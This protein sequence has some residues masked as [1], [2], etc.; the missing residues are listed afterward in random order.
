MS[1]IPSPISRST[2]LAAMATG[3]GERRGP[4]TEYFV[5]GVLS[6]DR[7][8]LARTI[9]LLESTNVHHAATARDVLAALLPESGRSIRVG[10]TG[11]PGVGKSTFIDQFGLNL[12]E[13]GHRV[14]V[15]A[16]DPTSSRT[17]GSI[18]GDKTRMVRLSTHDRAF[19][20]PSPA[21]SVL[22]GV[23]RATRE[24]IVVCEAAGYDVILV[25]TVGVGQS[26]TEVHDMVDFFLVLM[27]SGAGDDL[28]GI[29]KGVLELADMVAINKADGDN[30]ARARRAAGEYRS[31]LHLIRPA[32]TTW[33]PP[34]IT[35]SALENEGLDE[36]WQNIELHRAKT[37]ATGEFAQRRSNQ[38]V[39]WM[40]VML[41]ERLLAE[42]AR[43]PALTD[44]L[45]RAEVAVRSGEMT[46]STAVEQIWERYV[47]LRC[48][49]A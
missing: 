28:Q 11:V 49:P 46:P 34:V 3:D 12:V 37:E 32:S 25:E 7:A 40:R 10:I 29:K 44:T 15:L 48:E 1:L 35:C 36:L 14:A 31:A 17:G 38:Q 27:L 6:G 20:R 45:E 33:S 42:L 2:S 4:G 21:G 16:V 9:T 39:H 41:N 23:A 5:E 8:V 43:W 19:I 22:G 30:R 18:L 13:D 26:E 24:T 47:A